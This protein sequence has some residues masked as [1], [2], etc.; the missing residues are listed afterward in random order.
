MVKLDIF[1]GKVRFTW[2][3]SSINLV[4]KLDYLV[5]KIVFLVEDQSGGEFDLFGGKI[6]Y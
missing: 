2:W 1:G 3:K 6:K 5:V 4:I